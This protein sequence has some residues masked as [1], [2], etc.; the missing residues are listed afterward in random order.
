METSRNS[1]SSHLAPRDVSLLPRHWAWLSAQPRSASAT[2]RR[3]ID[4]ARQDRDGRFEIDAAR[5]RCYFLM[6]D[7]AGDTPGFEDACRA[8]YAGEAARF[9]AILAV[10]PQGVRRQIESVA[11]GVWP[12]PGDTPERA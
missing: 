1:P 9:A 6:R 7:L 12:V 4:E 2:L 3:L 10:W 5:E 11:L 8:L